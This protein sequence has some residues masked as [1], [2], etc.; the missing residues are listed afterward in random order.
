MPQRMEAESFDAK[1]LS[2]RANPTLLQAGRHIWHSGIGLAN[3][4]SNSHFD[5]QASNSAASVGC[6]G[7]LAFDDVFLVSS[8]EPR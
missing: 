8:M 1:R 5:F 3:N 6:S 4:H 2:R 7:S